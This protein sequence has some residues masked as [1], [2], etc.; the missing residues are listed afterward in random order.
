M[1]WGMIAYSMG[2]S[3]GCASD[4]SNYVTLAFLVLGTI[5]LA[6]PMLYKG[7][8]FILHPILSF[9]LKLIF[10][11]GSKDCHPPDVIYFIKVED[12]MLYRLI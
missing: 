6:A 4:F 7:F 9:A 2:K 1:V 11:G 3:D 12:L 5:W 10:N 8:G